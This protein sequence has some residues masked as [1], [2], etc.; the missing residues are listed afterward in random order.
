MAAVLERSIMLKLSV[1][2]NSYH[3]VES[4]KNPDCIV[5]NFMLSV[6]SFFFVMGSSQPGM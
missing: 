1:S 3:I 4:G 2:L 6:F 5:R